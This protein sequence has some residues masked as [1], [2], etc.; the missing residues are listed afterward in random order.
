MKIDGACH[1]GSITYEAEADP[2]MTG[3]CHCTDCQTLSGSAFRSVVPSRHGS[4]KLISG[5]PKIYVK[6]AESGIKRQQAFCPD[7]GTP[8]YSTTVDAGPKVHSIRVAPSVSVTN[9][10]PN[11]STGFARLSIGPV[12]SIPYRKP[13][14]SANSPVGH[15]RRI[16]LAR[17]IAS[18]SLCLLIEEPSSPILRF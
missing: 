10:C 11:C 4:F 5:E 14:S 12:I 16:L 1:C 15:R 2:E 18:F 9:L 13:R 17:S 3:I 6:T 7:C 8:I